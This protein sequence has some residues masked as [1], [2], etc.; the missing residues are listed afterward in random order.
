LSI[1]VLLR[2]GMDSHFSAEDVPPFPG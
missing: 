2:L 1:A